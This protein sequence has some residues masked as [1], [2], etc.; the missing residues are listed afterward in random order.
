MSVRR[1]P[2]ADTN[3]WWNFD[4]S[5]ARAGVVALMLSAHPGATITT[6]AY[7]LTTTAVPLT[8]TTPNNDSGWGRVDA[9][10]AVVAVANAGILSGTVRNAD[11]DEPIPGS[12]VS[13]N[14]LQ[15]ASTQTDVN[16]RYLLGVALRRLSCLG[17]RV[18][19]RGWL[20]HRRH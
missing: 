5:A 12:L 3:C 6:T 14:G 15:N 8:T 17:Q 4:G 20:G 18:R 9:Y 7:V 10:A 1:G 11:T 2:A 13:V 16:G 19:V